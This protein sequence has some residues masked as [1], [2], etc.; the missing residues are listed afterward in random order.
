MKDYSYFTP[1]KLAEEIL[2]TIDKKLFMNVIDISC[3]SWNLLEPARRILGCREI[4]GVDIDAEM[5]QYRIDDGLFLNL[6]G[7]IFAQQVC[8][9]EK[10][11]L[12]VSN[13]PFGRLK[14]AER[15]MRLYA[16]TSISADKEM[17]DVMT[18]R[19]ESEM[20]VANYLLLKKNGVMV[21]ILPRTVFVGDSYRKMRKFLSSRLY[22]KSIIE[23]PNGTF[24][25]AELSTVAFVFENR[26]CKD[27]T[28]LCRAECDDC[29]KI[30]KTGEVAYDVIASGIWDGRKEK[31][32]SHIDL[33][34]GIIGSQRFETGG[35]YKVLH[36]SSKFENGR[37][38]PS[39]RYSN[40]HVKNKQISKGDIIVNRVGKNAGCWTISEYDD[41]EVS[42]C[43]IVI[44][45]PSE[46]IL[47]AL[48][49]YS[50]NGRLCIEK[51]GVA[52]KYIT[53]SDL[54]I[55]LECE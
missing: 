41:C 28:I 26:S 55:L 2:K 34:R 38:F 23:L 48:E 53:Q 52:S 17:I 12:V 40:C 37:W 10:Y 43:I 15:I 42:D 6:D 14:D 24:K 20:I 31:K 33:F 46:K 35:K 25:N 22:V 9:H 19:Y 27:A 11:D 4:V 39:I 3:G 49:R 29:W 7:R 47:A 8:N 44:K 18:K 32:A 1:K 16:M 30:V 50:E 36:S 5:S 21:I 45:K 13:P 51:R 54:H